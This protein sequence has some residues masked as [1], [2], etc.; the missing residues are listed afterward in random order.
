MS[1]APDAHPGYEVVRELRTTKTATLHHARQREPFER[2]VLLKVPRADLGRDEAL[3]FFR[4]ERRALGL[5]SHDAIPKVYDAGEDAKGT[6]YLVLEFV[7]GPSLT[8]YLEEQKPSTSRALALVVD[9]CKA[10][11]YAHGQGVSHGQLDPEC[12]LVAEDHTRGVRVVDFEQ[13]VFDVGRDVQGLGSILAHVLDG[14]IRDPSTERDPR[15]LTDLDLIVRKALSEFSETR[16]ASVFALGADLERHLRGEP[17]LARPPTRRYLAYKFVTRHRIAVALTGAILLMLWIALGLAVFDWQRATRSSESEHR[18]RVE[19]LFTLDWLRFGDLERRYRKPWPTRTLGVE[20]NEV[21]DWLSE[22]SALLGREELVRAERNQ[23]AL[24][25]L[26]GGERLRRRTLES[27][28]NA[29]VDLRALRTRMSRRQRILRETWPL[30]E[31]CRKQ[32]LL[33]RGFEGVDL[34]PVPGLIPL[35]IDTDRDMEF[36]RQLDPWVFAVGGSGEVPELVDEKGVPVPYGSRGRPVLDDDTAILLVLIPGGTYYRGVQSVEPEDPNY[37]PDAKPWEG[38]VQ[39]VRVPPMF[40]GKYEATNAQF[41]AYYETAGVTPLAT[42]GDEY[43]GPARFP[44][45]GIRWNQAAAFANWFGLRLTSESEWEHAARAGT[46]GHFWNDQRHRTPTVPRAVGAVQET[47]QPNPWGI[48][49]V[50]DGVAEWCADH[51]KG[52]YEGTPLDGSPLTL[53]PEGHPADRTVRGGHWRTEFS[54]RVTTRTRFM[55]DYNEAYVGLR[56]ARSVPKL[57]KASFERAWPLQPRVEPLDLPAIDAGFSERNL[58]SDQSRDVRDVDAADLDG[59][60]DLDVL[61]ASEQDRTV[62]WFE[63]RGEG[64]FGPRQIITFF[65]GRATCVR[66]AD[67]DGD[68]DQDVL[69]AFERDHK[70]VWHENLGSGAFG[71]ERVISTDSTRVSCLCPVDVDRDG[72]VD[73]VVASRLGSKVVWFRSLGSRGF[74]PGRVIDP[75]AKGADFVHALDLDG[76]GD[77]DILAALRGGNEVRWYENVDCEFPIVRTLTSNRARMQC[78]HAADFDGD[79]DQ[80]VLSLSFGD[81]WIRWREQLEPGVF[82]SDHDIGKIESPMSVFAADLDGDGDVD[83]LCVSRDLMLIGWYENLDK[84][85][86]GPLRVITSS[87]E[88]ALR[89][90]AVDLDGD[91]ALDVLGA[92]RGDHT[93]AWYRNRSRGLRT[94]K[95]DDVSK[96]LCLHGTPE[97]GATIYLKPVR[98]SGTRLILWEPSPWGAWIG[99]DLVG[100]GLWCRAGKVQKFTVPLDPWLAGWHYEVRGIEAGRTPREN[101]YAASFSL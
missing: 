80:D 31:V 59:D 83:V 98:A 34:E 75:D 15:H 74:E 8:R 13:T 101:V 77:L 90:L 36:G 4:H 24:S 91:Q 78:V 39:E 97:L 38:P 51:Y 6:P 66:A 27:L 47:P 100:S 49:N 30:W 5:L 10:L 28:A 55:S 89:A 58:L 32:I 64:R 73:L 12:V 96:P 19:E 42:M 86:F 53:Y 63:N 84:G 61:A 94:L 81:K 43:L 35:G 72:R 65:G 95:M 44:V 76:D 11:Q 56:L 14:K 57:D 99:R 37:H 25:G 45:V 87:Q 40:F 50:L 62:A 1:V 93:V 41:T 3:E 29:L 46:T 85:S 69:A 68:G 82:G 26:G 71:Q 70:V 79:G 9:L 88:G 54:Q 48:H 7:D 20:L 16:Y 92:S 33:Q 22:A 2:D 60:G 18:A 67:V 17:I 21:D 52:T 23:A